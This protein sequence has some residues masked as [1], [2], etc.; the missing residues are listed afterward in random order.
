MFLVA[1]LWQPPV[2]QGNTEPGGGRHW[3]ASWM[4]PQTDAINGA[5][6]DFRPIVNIANQTFR[7]MVTPHRGGAAI[8]VKLS[9]AERPSPLRIGSATAAAA[10]AGASITSPAAELTFNGRRSVVI[11]AGGEVLSDAVDVNVAAWQRLA[12]SVNVQG[13]ALFL[14]QHLNGNA[15]SYYTKPGAGD[16]TRRRDGAAFPLTTTVVPIVSRVDVLAPKR[17]TAIVA[18]GDSITDGFVADNVGGLPQAKRGVVDK[19]VRYPDHLQRRLDD[20]GI[21]RV[22]VN[23][24]ISG[25]RV[26]A[27]GTVPLYGDAATRRLQ[28]D[29]ISVPGVEDLILLEGINDLGVPIGASADQVIAGYRNIIERL[30]SHRIRVHLGTI[31]PASN[32]LLDGTAT[33]PFSDATR[34]V[35]NRWIRRQKL[36]DSVIDFDR[37]LRD[38]SNSGILA[39]KYAGPDR[40]H[41]NPAGYRRMAMAVD[42]STLN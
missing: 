4:A 29:V 33:A 41:P 26:T 23:A 40:L 42:L 34:R 31:M 15:T 12:V 20:A 24:G 6:A 35:I 36:S 9:N 27:D 7:V 13:S 10:G 19:N 30:H 14:T 16:Q 5:D 21:D 39:P 1:T 22:V 28:R 37:A 3:V 11:P 18:F 2:A 8:R 25:N 17:T 38:R 32:A